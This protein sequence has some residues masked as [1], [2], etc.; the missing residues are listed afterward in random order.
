MVTRPDP[1]FEM[2]DPWVSPAG[3]KILELEAALWRIVPNTYTI[4]VPGFS[5][6]ADPFEGKGE[7]YQEAY[8]RLKEENARLK[9]NIADQNSIL[10]LMENEISCLYQVL[11][12]ANIVL[13]SNPCDPPL[14][15]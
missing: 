5:Q 9:T 14:M 10:D 11:E 1:D 8:E 12:A 4:E 13:G 3:Q 2:S 7:T 6:P 15:G